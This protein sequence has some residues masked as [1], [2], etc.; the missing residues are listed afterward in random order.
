M[1]Y[2]EGVS[3]GVCML[4]TMCTCALT[5]PQE[6]S[7]D[8]NERLGTGRPEQGSMYGWQC[9]GVQDICVAEC[10]GR[11]NAYIPC[12][13]LLRPDPLRQK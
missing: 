10:V 2:W 12:I 9:L 8:G 3:E 13:I 7:D 5:S 6:A 1:E 11:H 4:T